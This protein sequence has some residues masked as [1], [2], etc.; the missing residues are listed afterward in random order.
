M[1][2]NDFADRQFGLVT[3]ANAHASALSDRQIA[4]LV[5]NRSLIRV[6]RAVYRVPG[7]PPSPKQDALAACFAVG[8]HAFASHSTAA[9][10]FG[11]LRANKGKPEVLVARAHRSR[12]TTVVVHRAVELARNEVTRVGLIPLTRVARTLSDLAV[13]MDIEDALD[14]ALRRKLV[15][16][17]QLARYPRLRRLAEDRMEHGVPDSK[18]ERLAIDALRAAGLPEPVRQYRVRI[19]GR[20]YRPDLCYP[21]RRVSIELEGQAPHWG[22]WQYDHDRDNDFEL[23]RWRVLTYTWDD[24][25]NGS[26]KL[27]MQVGEILGLRPTRW[28][29]R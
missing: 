11:L 28:S 2:Y 26:L 10:V 7:S 4:K 12:L 6:H 25:T 23:D 19:R 24:A 13:R 20:N 8:T 27:I 9:G 18:L 22:Q 17:E 1:H 5:E 21:D 16:P 3:R 14:E 29:A 15:T